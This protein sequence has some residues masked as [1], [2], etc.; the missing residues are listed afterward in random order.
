MG[1]PS[2]F[3]KM[4]GL[5]RLFC[6]VLLHVTTYYSP[7]RINYSGEVGYG[8]CSYGVAVIY[9]ASGVLLAESMAMTAIKTH[10]CPINRDRGCVIFTGVGLSRSLSLGA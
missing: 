1:S 6:V 4:R 10:V 7:T 2:A 8:L 3:L 5:S 9:V